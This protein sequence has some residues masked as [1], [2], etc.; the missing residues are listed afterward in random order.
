ME[1]TDIV[2]EVN[3]LDGRQCDVLGDAVRDRQKALRANAKLVNI[4]TLKVGDDVTLT[5]LSPQYLEGV[6]ATVTKVGHRKGKIGVELKNSVGRFTSGH[7][8]DCPADCLVKV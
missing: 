8:I 6:E 5:G 1:F 3:H 7:T 4:A 2:Q